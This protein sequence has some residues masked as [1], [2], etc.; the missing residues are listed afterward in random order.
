MTNSTLMQYFEW[1]LPA[2]GKHWQ[3]LTDDAQ[4]LK[5]IGISMVW[6]PPAF[7]GTGP[8]DVG[9]GIYDLYDLGEFDQKGTVATKYGTKEDYL[10]AIKTLEDL[11][12]R[13]MAD[14]VLNHKASGDKKER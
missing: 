13:T 7:K 12:I 6:L 10:K 3:R 4:H 5:D 2:D 14:I 8:E 9:Y 1:Y 11:D